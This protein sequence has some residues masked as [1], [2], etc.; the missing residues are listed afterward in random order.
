MVGVVL[1]TPPTTRFWMGSRNFFYL[2]KACASSVRQ[3][4]DPWSGKIE[5]GLYKLSGPQ[6]GHPDLI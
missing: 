3:K 4:F 6:L 1:P 2:S 5:L